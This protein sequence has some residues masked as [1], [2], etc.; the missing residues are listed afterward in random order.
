MLT[1]CKRCVCSCVLSLEP[2]ITATGPPSATPAPSAA[3]LPSDEAHS[4]PFLD[5]N[6][7]CAPVILSQKPISPEAWCQRRLASASTGSRPV[8]MGWE[9]PSLVT[10]PHPLPAW[11]QRLKVSVGQTVNMCSPPDGWNGPHAS[12]CCF[13]RAAAA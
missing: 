1:H 4:L 3:A 10:P 2:E 12:V 6:P 8:K 5:L 7:V 13:L 9:T 11:Y